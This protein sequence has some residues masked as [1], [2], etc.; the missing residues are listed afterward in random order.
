MVLKHY[1]N[2]FLAITLTA[3]VAL[4]ALSGLAGAL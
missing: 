2:I 1:P 3:L 4:L